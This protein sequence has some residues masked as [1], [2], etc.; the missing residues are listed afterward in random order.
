MSTLP[1]SADGSRW[2]AMFRRGRDPVF[3]LNRRRRLL[4]AN[5]AWERLTQSSLGEA[6]GMTFTRRETGHALADLGRALAPPDD[7]LAGRATSARRPPP[8]RASG[9]PWWDVDFFPLTDA[10]RLLG[11]IG[12]VRVAAGSAEPQ[13]GPTPAAW[14]QLRHDV[15][16]RYTFAAWDSAVPAVRRAVA[17]AR[18]VATTGT[19]AV[20]L[21]EAGVG[22]RTLA[23]TI[24]AAADRRELPFIGLDCGRLPA[25]A[26]RA[27]VS[28]PWGLRQAD[29]AGLVY[30]ND[31]GALPL[32]LQVEIARRPGDRPP[33]IAG[34]AGDPRSALRAGRLAEELF[35]SLAV[36]VIELPAVRHRAADWPRL[37]DDARQLVGSDAALAPDAAAALAAYGWPGNR[38]ELA[39][40]LREAAGRATGGVIAVADLPAAVRAATEA[41]PARPAELPRLDDLLEQVEA[42]MIRLALRRAKGNRS[43]AAD[44]LGVWRPRLLRRIAAL[45]IAPPEA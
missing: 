11:V 23:R 15:I 20:I 14:G 18:L 7:V 4:Y 30:L 43:R 16:N 8:G 38:A 21:G 5:A 26:V 31:P 12:R 19:A 45:G 9:P 32:D 27:V 36:V 13:R 34:F 22:K 3:V 39:T 28:G 1:E 17:Q 6:R 33:V 37:L 25:A 42:R 2:P 35:E 41:A 29:G 44:L 40:T 24:H 10:D